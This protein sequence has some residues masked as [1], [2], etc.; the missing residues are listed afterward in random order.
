L[1]LNLADVLTGLREKGLKLTPQRH[2]ILRVLL[3]AGGPL[4]A[5]E[6]GNALHRRFP[7]VGLGTV[8]RTL[9]TFKELGVLHEIIFP[10]GGKRFE[11]S[12]EH[13]HHLI[14]LSCGRAVSYPCCPAECLGQI[15]KL[16][17]NFKVEEHS[18]TVFGYCGDCRRT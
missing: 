1:F 12:R 10:D 16:N 4:T 2:Q 6:I 14:C 7:N 11:L 8:Y 15:K 13:R 3:R 18:L 17:P 9:E 5:K